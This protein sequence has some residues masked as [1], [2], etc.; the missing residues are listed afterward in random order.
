MVFAPS[1]D[2]RSERQRTVTSTTCCFCTL[3]GSIPH[4]NPVGR[5]IRTTADL[6]QDGFSQREKPPAQGKGEENHPCRK[7]D[8]QG[9]GEGGGGGVRENPEKHDD[10]HRQCPVRQKAWF[11]LRLFG[12]CAFHRLPFRW[13]CRALLPWCVLFPAPILGG[14]AFSST[15]Q[16]AVLPFFPSPFRKRDIF[17]VPPVALCGLASPPIG[18]CCP[19]LSSFGADALPSPLLFVVAFEKKKK[20]VNV[21]DFKNESMQ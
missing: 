11:L 18:W 15:L 10:H 9:K 2:Q 7:E 3:G 6:S 14:E 19:C 21:V 16:K 20:R 1:V 4:Q 5:A 8:P 13:S 12:G 17:P